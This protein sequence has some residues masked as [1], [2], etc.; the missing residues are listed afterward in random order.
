LTDSKKEQNKDSKEAIRDLILQKISMMKSE[1]GIDYFA[2][3]DVHMNAT[4][5]QIKE[6][7]YRLAKL[8]HPDILEKHGLKD[9]KEQANVAFKGINEAYNVLSDKTKKHKY[10]TG[11]IKASSGNPVVDKKK[12][13]EE[14]KMFFHKGQILLQK[15]G[16][17]ESEECLRKAVSLD[18][19]QGKYFAALGW[20][21]FQNP[22]SRESQRLEDAKKYFERAIELSHQDPQPLYYMSL[23]YKALGDTGRQ[24]R[25]LQD[26][27]AINPKYLDAL[28]E[29]RLLRIRGAKKPGLFDMLSGFFAKKKK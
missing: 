5:S 9:L 17:R 2:M 20:S 25:Y 29:M 27:L 21:I 23:Y 11:E 14:A 7:Y 6:S 10:I 1:K 15:R 12:K 24:K 19:S 28:R 26:A 3:L 13:A 22:E 4:E 16:Y 18:D 8:V